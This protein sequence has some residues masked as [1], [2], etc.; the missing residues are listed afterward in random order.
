MRASVLFSFWRLVGSPLL[1]LTLEKY[2]VTPDED[3]RNLDL[4]SLIHKDRR[5]PSK[6]NSSPGS[7][8]PKE[9]VKG[10]RFVTSCPSY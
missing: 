5:V 6:K 7:L 1:F 2:R 10:G 8:S 4:S 9:K 3:Y